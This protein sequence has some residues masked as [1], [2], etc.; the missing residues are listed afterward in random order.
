[1]AL[2][3]LVVKALVLSAGSLWAIRDILL[4]FTGK[5]TLNA[6]TLFP[7]YN[8]HRLDAGADR[9]GL[10]GFTGGVLTPSPLLPFDPLSPPLLPPSPFKP[11]SKLPSLLTPSSHPHFHFQSPPLTW[12]SPRGGLPE[13]LPGRGLPDILTTLK[14]SL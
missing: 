2:A 9:A 4:V 13:G 12:R 3:F 14:T 8:A 11:H 5:A 10:W 6:S 7:K 1:M